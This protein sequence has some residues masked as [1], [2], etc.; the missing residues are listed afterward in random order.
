GDETVRGAW[1]FSGRGCVQLLLRVLPQDSGVQG[2]QFGPGI[3]TELF[4]KTCPKLLVD[5]K[6]SGAFVVPPQCG[7]EEVVQ[8]RPER[9]LPNQ[10]DEACDDVPVTPQVQSSARPGDDGGPT[11]LQQGGDHR[12]GQM[13]RPD[14][15]ERNT[16]P[17]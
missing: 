17:T 9:V 12:I 2:D 13:L 11:L 3:H 6:C 10:R 4:G 5:G 15:G 8:T 7:D 14:P 16:A 1:R